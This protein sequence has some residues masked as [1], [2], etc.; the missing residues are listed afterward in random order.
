V[1]VA[2]KVF[3]LEL[4]EIGDF[5]RHQIIVRNGRVKGYASRDLILGAA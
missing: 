4:G 5:E 3:E 1:F 2:E